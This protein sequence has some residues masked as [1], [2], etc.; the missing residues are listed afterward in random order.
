MMKE[1]PEKIATFASSLIGD[2]LMATSLYRSL[3]SRY[4]RAEITLLTEVPEH[5][6][7]AGFNTFDR[8]ANYNEGLNL[9]SLY[10]LI[11]LPVFCGDTKVRTSFDRFQKVISLDRLHSDLRQSWRNKWSGDY[12]HLLFHKHQFE[13]NADLARA[14]GCS[15]EMPPLYCPQ[16]D[17][18]IYSHFKGRIGLFINTPQNEFQALPNRQ[19]PRMHW[20]ALVEALG[21]SNV[22]LV[23]G[24][25]DL[26]N[27]KHLAAETGALYEA[28]AR[29][30][31][32]TA[33]CRNL[34]ALAT[35]DGG[36]MHVAATT[37]VPI[38]S[39]HGTSSP[40]LLHPWIYP[41]GK[42]IAILSP[43]SC[44][45]CQRSYRLQVCESGLTRMD[46]MQNLRPESV[47]RAL[48]EITNLKSGTCLMMQGSHLMTKMAY[49]RSLKR[50]AEFTVNYNISRAA[51]RLKIHGPLKP[52][53]HWSNAKASSPGKLAS[54]SQGTH[55]FFAPHADDV[56]LSCGGTIHSL[57][58]QNESV[59][60]IGVFAGIPEATRYSAYAR[61]LHAK[62]RL[63]TNPI[64]SRW[65]EGASAMHE[66]GITLF[67]H[68]DYV[69]GPYRNAPDG[70]PLYAVD[71][72]LVGALANEDRKLRDLIAQRIRRR[73]DESP[74]ATA[75]Y[76]PLSLGHHVDHQI[77]F[78]IGLELSATGQRVR[79]Y[80][81]YPYAEAYQPN[82]QKQWRSEVMPVVI[83]P[84]IRAACS[85]A[86]QL[87][88]MG[89]SPS[90][91]EKRLRNFGVAV[92]N[93]NPG[94]RYWEPA[95]PGAQEIVESNAVGDCPLVRKEP[96]IG[97]RDFV[98]FLKTFRWHDLDEVL[99][100]GDG[101]CLDIGC[102]P[103]RH[104]A[105]VQERGYHWMGFDR[106][107]FA[108]ITARSDAVALPLKAKSIAGVMAWQMLEYIEQ[109]E[110]VIA[111]AARV[112]EPGG[113]FC[114]S[115]SFLEPVHGR[116]CFNL[117]PLILKRMLTRNGFADVEIKPGLN[118]LALVLWTWLRSIPIPFA[119]RLAIPLALA[120]LAPLAA[121]TFLISWMRLRLGIG[122]SH[123]MRWLTETAP[124][125]FAGHVLFVA[126]KKA[127]LPY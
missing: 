60:V 52:S 89:G 26:P 8:A 9:D 121:I 44:S 46:C 105:L 97:L 81:D 32:F 51:V 74:Q 13:L 40:I 57:I 109:P 42:C 69:E 63:H 120:V 87:R 127:R 23:G 91:L 61:H 125:D 112:L 37:G 38:V 67:E 122:G 115:V 116:T 108:A 48:M 27:L 33:L 75:L 72:E 123:T 29:L 30:S 79:F 49:L 107:D 22:V 94:E 83:E 16:G 102:G 34:R 99:P 84:K 64:Q 39:L 104:R 73:L 68:W 36:G 2:T 65:Q 25:S 78:D 92:G 21:P 6:V 111:E 95:R 5:P 31:E 114:G 50:E 3:R 117:S 113:V 118:G 110:L 85:Y 77:L 86:S 106:R 58:S 70:F 82:G 15:G 1:D 18:A 93:G 80:E 41:E 76:F 90:V 55:V 59:E 43:N 47:A 19:W 20:K 11:V 62:W 124:L 4:P 12:T 28:T 101:Y 17:P 35:T 54:T 66:L 56:V 100:V 7:L 119:D 14:A 126:R 10:D 103:G 53:A 88:G 24:S 98:K 45:P 71:E 96:R